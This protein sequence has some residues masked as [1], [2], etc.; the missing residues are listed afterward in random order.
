MSC[1][2]DVTLLALLV[3]EAEFVK[4]DFNVKKVDHRFRK[5]SG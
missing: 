1:Y 3:L 4:F 2:S 5:I